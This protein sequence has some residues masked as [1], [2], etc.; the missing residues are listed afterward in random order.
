MKKLYGVLRKLI[1]KMER[2]EGASLVE[3]GLLIG[4]IAIACMAILS[5][6]GLDLSAV[7]S[8]ADKSINTAG[9]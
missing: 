7:F 2:E 4:L 8:T 9:S 5:T 6:L 1:S 3:Y